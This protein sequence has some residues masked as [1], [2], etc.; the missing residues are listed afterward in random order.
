[1]NHRGGGGLLAVLRDVLQLPAKSQVLETV[2]FP[3]AASQ[4]DYFDGLMKRTNLRIILD[5]PPGMEPLPELDG[6]LFRI[7]QQSMSNILRHS[8][9]DTARVR[10][11]RDTKSVRMSPRRLMTSPYGPT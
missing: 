5:A 9:A 1:M 6:T 2:L 7:V 3:D 10:L 11:E 4:Q 8:G